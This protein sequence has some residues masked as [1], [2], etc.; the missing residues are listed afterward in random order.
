MAWRPAG[1]TAARSRPM[2]CPLKSLARGFARMATGEGL[3]PV[4][5]A[6]AKRL[7]AACMAEPFHV[8]G[9][10][11]ADTVM[12]EAGR[13]RLFT[14]VGA[15]GVFC[16]ALPERGLAIALKCD[17][18]AA[19]AAEVMVAATLRDL[20]AA[21]DPLRAQLAVLARPVQKN[22]RGIEVGSLRPAGPLA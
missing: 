9:T 6:A 4:R 20:L 16:A 15:E 10:D 8:A 21:D 1:R 17:D 2:P 7:F 19:R 22:W 11:R 3:S 18:G 12:M 13:G 5:A 14:K